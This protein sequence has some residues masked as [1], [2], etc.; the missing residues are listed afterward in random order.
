MD[1]KSILALVLI[2]VVIILMPYYQRIIMGDRPQEQQ[3]LVKPDTL[4]QPT[5]E[6]KPVEESKTENRDES[7]VNKKAA[8]LEQREPKENTVETLVKIKQDSSE[9]EVTIETDRILVQISNKGGGS[10]KKYILKKYTKYDSSYVNLISPEIKNNLYLGFQDNTGEFI[11]ANNYLFFTK[12]T[13]E[14]KYLKEGERF[15]IRYTLNIAGGELQKTYIFYDNK[16]H[17]DVVVKFSRPNQMLLNN[18]YRFGWVNGLPPTESY[19]EDDNNYNQVN[20]YI[21]DELEQFNITEKGRTPEVSLTGRAVWF[22][23]RTKYFLAAVSNVNANV[24]D[25]VYYSGLGIQRQNYVQRLYDVGFNVRETSGGQADTMRIYMGPLDHK[26]LKAYDNNLDLLI[27]NNGWYERT[28]RFFS[29]IILQVL[30]FMHGFIPNYGIVIIIFS[31]LIK[32]IVYPLTKKSY[33]SMKEM[34]KIQPLVQE[35]KEKYKG[36]PQRMNKEMMKLYKEHGVNPMGGCLPMLLQMPLLFALFIVFRSTI[37][38]RGAMFIPG[39]IEDLSRSDTLFHLPFSLPFYGNEF[40][41]LPILMAI[42][43]IFQSKM[44]MQDPKQKAM[45]Y[46]MPVF[47]L[48]IFN[49]FPAGLNLYYTLFNLLTI[50]QQK[51][52]HTEEKVP[53]PGLK[54]KK[55]K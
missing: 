4:A 52:I 10:L 39:W 55:K 47:M 27:L 25:G 9:K 51:F 40:N 22:A 20:I 23:I 36:D 37:Q 28:F 3:A 50:V 30:E 19:V 2:A 32:L 44:T 29:L 46:V 13:V 24:D 33:Q 7:A 1:K 12:N 17:F 41:L 18:T 8:R 48:F 31:I 42:T 5:A 53:D 14:K 49:R 34:Q 21:G 26:E 15:K 54:K 11:E 43:M 16:Y 35:L 6:K 45:V 38:L